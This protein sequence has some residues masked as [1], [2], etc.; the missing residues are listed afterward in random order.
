MP[1]SQGCGCEDGDLRERAVALQYEEAGDRTSDI[2]SS[3][4]APCKL[5]SETVLVSDMGRTSAVSNNDGRPSDAV[6]GEAREL[7]FEFVRPL[8]VS[9]P[10]IAKPES[11]DEF[12]ETAETG[13]RDLEQRLRLSVV[14]K[15]L[16]SCFF[17][18][19]SSFA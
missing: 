1:V 15:V 12:S 5:L 10:A 13:E 14:L 8:P 2:L 6:F 18:C 17:R 9:F 16:A 11:L 4:I 19:F 7:C 3:M